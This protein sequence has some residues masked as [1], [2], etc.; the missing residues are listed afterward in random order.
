MVSTTGSDFSI[1]L[2]F[3]VTFIY[4]VNKKLEG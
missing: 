2:L 1:F 3:V 4:N